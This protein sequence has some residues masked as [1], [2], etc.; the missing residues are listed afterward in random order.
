MV[1]GSAEARVED[2]LAP[3]TWCVSMCMAG[4]ASMRKGSALNSE[5]LR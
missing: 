5:V 4:D 3:L 2:T 1:S